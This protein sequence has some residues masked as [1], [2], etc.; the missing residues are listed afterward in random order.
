MTISN[1]NY[2]AYNKGMIGEHDADIAREDILQK[3]SYLRKII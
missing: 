1:A 3:E 2:N